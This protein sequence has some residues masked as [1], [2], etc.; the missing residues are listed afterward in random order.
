MLHGDDDEEET[1]T[2]ASDDMVLSSQ[3]AGKR[4]RYTFRVRQLRNQ[5][6]YIEAFTKLYSLE[7]KFSNALDTNAKSAYFEQWKAVTFEEEEDVS[8]TNY[9][10]NGELANYAANKSQ[11]TENEKS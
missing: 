10:Y 3:S 1:P 8:Q 4:Q 7:N 9:N 6:S 5:S 2:E 11:F